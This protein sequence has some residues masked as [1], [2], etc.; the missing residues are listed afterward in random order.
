MKIILASNQS[1]IDK[2]GYQLT[3]IPFKDMRVG[4]IITATKVASDLSFLEKVNESIKKHGIHYEDFDIEGK[5]K[6]EIFAFFSDKNIIHMEGG[7]TFYLLKVIRGTGFD[8]ILKELFEKGIVYIGASAGSYVM[9]PS[10][11]VSTWRKENPDLW[12]GL[13]DLTALNYAPFV[14]KV[15]YE[16]EKES[17]TREKMKNL[18]YPLRILRDGQG[19]LVEDGKSYFKGEGNE[20]QLN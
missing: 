14:L 8:Q 11:E 19:I 3:G 10:I 6:E 4:H 7:N 17:L 9:C 16:D 5:S 1:F 13:T 18:R 2:Y 12:Y 20:V 15:H